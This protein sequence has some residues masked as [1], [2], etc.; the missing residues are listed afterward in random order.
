MSNWFKSSHLSGVR[1]HTFVNSVHL[2]S[3]SLPTPV[4]KRRANT[5]I[6]PFGETCLNRPAS[7]NH[8]M[9]ECSR[10]FG[11]NAARHNYLVNK[12]SNFL[13]K[14]DFKASIKPIMP[15]GLSFCKSDLLA[16]KNNTS[17]GGVPCSCCLMIFWHNKLLF[18]SD[19][20]SGRPRYLAP[21]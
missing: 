17:F 14:S 7:L 3:S 1:G 9:Q 10:T 4:R 21:I 15:T 18:L 12:I 19:C 20:S 2:R 16:T 8:I 5:R 11:Q 13:G 6:N